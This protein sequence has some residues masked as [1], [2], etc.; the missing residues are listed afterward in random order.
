MA[1]TKEQTAKKKPQKEETRMV[2]LAAPAGITDLNP[3]GHGAADRLVV[4]TSNHD[5]IG[6][7][8]RWVIA[9]LKHWRVLFKEMRQPIIDAEK[10][11][12]TIEREKLEAADYFV[13][14]VGQKLLDWEL[15]EDR[16]AE[17]RQKEADAEVERQAE[18]D[19]AAQVEEMRRTAEAAKTKT[20]QKRIER[21][22]KAVEKAP[23]EVAGA[24]PVG[25]IYRRIPGT[26]RRA[27]W[28]GHVD[29]VGQ[30]LKLLAEGK[31]PSTMIEFKQ[32]ELNK[33]ASQHQE[34]LAT[35]FPGLVA[36]CD[37]KL[38]G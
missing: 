38:A 15:E 32:I 3:Y 2:V 11:H 17:E 27:P 22:A 25:S 29:H 10:A 37:K 1:K 14:H 9:R 13:S 19:R 16:L 28:T 36:V 8:R 20:E 24:A 4:T 34:R 33:L 21:Q 30:V 26:S 31:L 7:T 35:V 12:R 23:L 18:A 5:T 6:Q